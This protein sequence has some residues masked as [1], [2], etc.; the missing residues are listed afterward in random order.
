MEMPPGSTDDNAAWR[1]QDDEDDWA[2]NY[3]HWLVTDDGSKVRID[4]KDIAEG[5]LA[6]YL[7]EYDKCH[8]GYA[9]DDLV[10]HPEEG[11]SE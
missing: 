11:A 9:N 10:Y 2:Y 6:I 5:N 3:D 8:E 1:Y 7:C 4:P